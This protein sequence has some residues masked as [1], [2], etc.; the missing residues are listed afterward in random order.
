MVFISRVFHAMCC[1]VYFPTRCPNIKQGRI[2]R[3]EKQLVLETQ[4]MPKLIC[5]EIENNP[6]KFQIKMQPCGKWHVATQHK[7][8]KL[9]KAVNALQ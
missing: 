8:A 9:Q 2:W 3:K 7:L 6:L 5:R 4:Q 1:F